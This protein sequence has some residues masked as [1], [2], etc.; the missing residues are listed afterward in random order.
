M[1]DKMTTLVRI[2]RAQQRPRISK[3]QVIQMGKVIY[4]NEKVTLCH[5]YCELYGFSKDLIKPFRG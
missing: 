1:N 4:E 2:Q 5:H 3:W